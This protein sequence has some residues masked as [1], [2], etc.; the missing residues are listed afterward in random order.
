MLTRSVARRVVQGKTSEE[1]LSAR[2]SILLTGG[3]SLAIWGSI[4]VL[5]RY[6]L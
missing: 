4:I 6:L 3:I 2:A 5:A 1:R